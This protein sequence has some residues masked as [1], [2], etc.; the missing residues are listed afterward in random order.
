M[1]EAEHNYQNTSKTTLKV[2]E[3]KCQINITF[4]KRIMMILTDSNSPFIP[5]PLSLF[6]MDAFIIII[7]GERE[8]LC[9][10]QDGFC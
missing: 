5:L 7:G 3:L 6:K 9:E 8:A 10:I 2:S 1:N 4:H